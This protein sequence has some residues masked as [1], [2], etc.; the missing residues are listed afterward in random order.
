MI[1][2]P[3]EEKSVGSISLAAYGKYFLAGGNVLVLLLVLLFLIFG[4][5][6]PFFTCTCR[7]LIIMGVP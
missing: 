3:P 5:V 4:E 6:C 2:L 1:I 7:L